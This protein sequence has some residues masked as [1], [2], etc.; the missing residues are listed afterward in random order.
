MHSLL[1]E[2]ERHE[3]G[4]DVLVVLFEER[5]HVLVVE[6][7]AKTQ[8]GDWPDHLEQVPQHAEQ[9]TPKQVF[10]YVGQPVGPHLHDEPE[11]ENEHNHLNYDVDYELR[12]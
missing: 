11:H 2:M 5:G 12:S 4:E 7:Q 9:I 10:E 3:R 1:L 6:K 8:L